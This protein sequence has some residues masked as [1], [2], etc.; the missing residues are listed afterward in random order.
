MG[1][2]LSGFIINTANGGIFDGATGG[3]VF[4]NFALK[5]V[6]FSK[7]GQ[8]TAP[9]FYR[10]RGVCFIENVY[11]EVNDFSSS[12]TS[13]G[14]VAFLYMGGLNIENC[15]FV[16]N[17]LKSGDP[18]GAICGRSFRSSLTMKNTYIV[19]QGDLCAT[20]TSEYNTTWAS[21]ND[22]SSCCYSTIEEFKAD[23]ANDILDFS[24]FNKYWDLEQDIPNMYL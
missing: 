13:G 24:M 14:V 10:L 12:Y 21:V 16:I 4:K 18:N 5:N 7:T 20:K 15:I 22:F 11:I 3:A 17:G 1:H 19:T 2:T 6:T 23:I 8:C 9:L